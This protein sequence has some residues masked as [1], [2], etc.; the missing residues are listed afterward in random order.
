MPFIQNI[1]F[2]D[3]MC[4]DHPTD[5]NTMMINIV[6][7]CMAFPE[8]KH[9]FVEIHRFEFLDIE[10]DDFSISEEFRVTDSQAAELVRLLQHALTNDMNVVVSCVAGVCR[11][12]AVCEVGVMLGFVDTNRFRIP[13][14]LVKSKMMNVLGWNYNEDDRK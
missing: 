7:P 9:S 13:N 10:E 6:D 11:S 1:S 3:V 5:D 2:A 8:S 12:G 4:G 14:L